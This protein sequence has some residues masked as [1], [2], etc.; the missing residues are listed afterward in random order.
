MV[1]MED[2]VS[3]IREMRGVVHVFPL[4]DTCRDRIWDIEKDIK[5]ALGIPV[6]N[7]GVE[8]CLARKHIICIIKKASFRPPPEPTVMLVSDD[9]VV[10]GE[11]VLPHVKK[12]FLE[13]VK[14]EIIWLSEEFVLYPDRRGGRREYFVMPPVSFPEVEEMGMQNVVSCSPAAPADMMLRQMHGY[15]DDPKLASILVGF[16]TPDGAELS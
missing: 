8:E 7:K 13:N 5:A 9:G 15:E 12:K 14:E 11:E 16:D 1:R 2:I 4:N 10:L 6:I 3:R